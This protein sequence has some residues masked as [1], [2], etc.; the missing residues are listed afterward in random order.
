MQIRF[1]DPLSRGWGRMK[2]ALFQPFDMKKWFLVGFTAFLAG[3]AD[4]HK[5][6]CSVHGVGSPNK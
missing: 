3:L 4:C 5:K 6:E 1:I 2:K